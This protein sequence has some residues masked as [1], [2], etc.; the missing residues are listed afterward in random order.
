MIT[1]SDSF[2]T[3]DLEKYYA[4]LPQGNG[5]IQAYYENKG[6]KMVEPG[7]CYNSGTNEDWL[8]VSDLQKLIANNIM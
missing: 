1:S 7:F 3:I 2:N 6:G 5:Q 8:S 4:I